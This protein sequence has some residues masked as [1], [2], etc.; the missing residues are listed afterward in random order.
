MGGEA[1]SVREENL[2]RD[3]F[4]V[5]AKK[6]ITAQLEMSRVLREK[7]NHIESNSLPFPAEGTPAASITA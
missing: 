1:Q 2:Q 7:K 6:Y 4:A 3:M 5:A